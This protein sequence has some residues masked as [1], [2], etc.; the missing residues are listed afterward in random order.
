[1]ISTGFL[2]V[3]TRSL[4]RFE[5]AFAL[6]KPSPC[7]LFAPAFV[8][9]GQRMGLTAIE[10]TFVGA[11]EDVTEET[12]GDAD[13]DA[14]MTLVN[15]SALQDADDKDAGLLVFDSATDE[16][17]AFPA[18]HVTL[19]TPVTASAL[20]ANAPIFIPRSYANKRS[21][22]LRVDAPVFVPSVARRP[23]A[24]R[25]DAPVFVPRAG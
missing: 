7:R 11:C 4:L 8:S 20:K 5:Q 24:L 15:E 16:S 22:A 2:G 1:M 3:A 13:P 18:L 21:L 19:K 14:E 9:F 25:A 10:E 12:G 17:L 23:Q 6:L